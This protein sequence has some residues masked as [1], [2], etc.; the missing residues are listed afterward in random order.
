MATD[1]PSTGL[2]GT[3]SWLMDR[4]SFSEDYSAQVLGNLPRM[5]LMDLKE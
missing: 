2:S 4:G 3:R 5:D 1:A